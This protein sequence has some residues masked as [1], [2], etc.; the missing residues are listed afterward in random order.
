MH[1]YELPNSVESRPYWHGFTSKAGEG[2]VEYYGGDNPTANPK[3]WMHPV[4]LTSYHARGC[5]KLEV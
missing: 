5:A 4:L 3:I 2:E 1:P